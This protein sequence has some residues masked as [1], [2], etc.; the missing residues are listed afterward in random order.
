LQAADQPCRNCPGF[1]ET[2]VR[3]LAESLSGISEIRTAPVQ[4]SILPRPGQQHPQRPAKRRRVRSVYL[5]DIG[6]EAAAHAGDVI[7]HL[8]ALHRKGQLHKSAIL[9]VR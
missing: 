1:T 2:A 9:P 6:L 5:Q 3:E 8:P 4:A 7:D